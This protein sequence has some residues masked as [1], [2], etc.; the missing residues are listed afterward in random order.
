MTSNKTTFNFQEGDIVTISL[1]YR[2]SVKAYLSQPDFQ[3]YKVMKINDDGTIRLVGVFTDIPAKYVEGVPLDSEL[4]QQLYYDNIFLG[5]AYK[6]G[7]VHIVE[8]I[9]AR[10]PL[11]TNIEDNMRNTP[12]W[13][14]IHSGEF[15]FIHELQHWVEK[16]D[17]HGSIR[18]N[19]FWQ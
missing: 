9:S 17:G 8:D 6:V 18:I 1:D 11:L 3:V 5:R 19:Q 7:N 12:L 13:E 16:N 10:Q 15:R 4:T 2:S 14:A